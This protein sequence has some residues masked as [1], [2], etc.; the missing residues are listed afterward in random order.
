MSTNCH[1]KF[2]FNLDFNRA[3]IFLGK[4]CQLCLP[5]VLFVAALLYLSLSLWCCGLDMDLF[6]L[7]SVFSY[8]LYINSDFCFILNSILFL[9][10][11][12]I[13]FNFI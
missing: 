10:Y 2:G 3:P 8:L 12:A 1:Y 4:N 9:I 11:K 5:S 13:S 6:V 7:V